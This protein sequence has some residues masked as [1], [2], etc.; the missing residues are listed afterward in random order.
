MT[1]RNIRAH[2]SRGLLPPPQLRGRTGY[3][4]AGAHRS[5]GAHPGAAERWLQP[6]ADQ[7]P[8]RRRGRVEQR[9][10][11][12]QAR[13]GAAVRRRGAADDRDRRADR[14][15]GH[16]R[17]EDAHEVALARPAA[18]ASRRALRGSQPAPGEGRPRAAQARRAARA[19]AGV[20]R[21]RARARRSPRADL[22]RP[23]PRDGLDA[24][25]G[26]GAARRGLAGGAG[27]AGPV[28]AARLR[29]AAGGLRAGDAGRDRPRERRGAQADGGARPPTLRRRR[30][31][32]AASAPRRRAG[33][34]CDRRREGDL[35]ALAAIVT[36]EGVREWWGPE[37]ALDTCTRTCATTGSRSR[38]RSAARSR[39]GSGYPRSSRRTTARRGWTSSWRRRSRATATG[40]RRCD[41]PR[42][43][44]SS[45]RGHH[46]LTIDPAAANERAIGAYASLGFKPV[47]IM[48]RYE[49]GRDG[50]FHDGLLMDLL[51]AGADASP[52][53]RMTPPRDHASSTARR[54][55][56]RCCSNAR[57]CRRGGGGAAAGGDA[58]AGAQASVRRAVD[59]AGGLRRRRAAGRAATSARSCARR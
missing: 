47:G 18:P 25:R 52:T 53:A 49:R 44:S 43:G 29:L 42:A 6:R 20:H 55:R 19:V 50:S 23:L 22:R 14:R 48:R 2:Q 24:V 15:V 16:G 8:A 54:S 59:A 13:A 58:G 7:A 26:G 21:D 37:A 34:R 30:R 46:R 45:E 41:W 56:A 57:G 38:S 12:L 36:S 35:D 5:P 31:D 33:R 10:A 1:V 32:G 9:G 28:A 27:R 3:Y 51:A 4:G 17:P 39:A 40:P 11:A